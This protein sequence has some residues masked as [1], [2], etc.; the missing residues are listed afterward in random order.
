MSRTKLCVEH[1]SAFSFHQEKLIRCR[2]RTG[3]QSR[4]VS[5]RNVAQQNESLKIPRP[6]LIGSGQR[7]EAGSGGHKINTR[8]CKRLRISRPTQLLSTSW[9][10][11]VN[12]IPK[13]G[14]YLFLNQITLRNRILS[15][16][17][18][19]YYILV[20]KVTQ[21]CCQFNTGFGKHI[22][23]MFRVRTGLTKP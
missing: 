18:V 11:S 12:Q 10:A 14:R 16:H 9:G 1:F 2:V 19:I 17:Y 23:T 13:R 3:T 15:K 22:Y 21:S 5:S 20:Y 8:F 6:T 7:L 4:S